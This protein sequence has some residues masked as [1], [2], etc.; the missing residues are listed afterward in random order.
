MNENDPDEARP[1]QAIRLAE[2]RKNRGFTDAK[3]AAAYFGWNY[4]SYSQHERGERGLK[5]PVAERYS[6]AF[7]VSSG[8]LLTGE[9]AKETGASIPVM[10]RVGAGAEIEPEFEQVPAEGLFEVEVLMPLPPGMIGFEVVG[11]SMYPRY[12]DGD[13]VVC[14][15]EGEPA[16]IAYGDEAAVRTSDGRRFLKRV[17]PVN[18]SFTLES[19]NAP[20]IRNVQLEWASPVILTVR[21]SKRLE[22]SQRRLQKPVSHIAKPRINR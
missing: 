17:I 14:A 19:H 13:V 9:G 1:D 20:P 12:D 4:T 15:R 7:R 21:K 2:A 18:G 22:V 10:G 6:K 3:S 16:A 5:R 8:W 11:E